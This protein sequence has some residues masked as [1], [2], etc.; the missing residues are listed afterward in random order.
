MATQV[1]AKV[2]L[3]LAKASIAMEVSAKVGAGMAA[4]GMAARGRIM[5][6]A[7]V[8]VGKAT[9]VTGIMA[10]RGSAKGSAKG[11]AMVAATVL[12]KAS[13]AT[14]AQQHGIGMAKRDTVA[15][16]VGKPAPARERVAAA[17]AWIATRMKIGLGPLLLEESTSSTHST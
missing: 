13:T 2:A 9:A 14:P 6:A 7:A 15:K 17:R 5:V 11:S 1:P 16:M 10:A 12:A 8:L 3:V 4:G